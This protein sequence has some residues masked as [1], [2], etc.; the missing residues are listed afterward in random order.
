MAAMASVEVAVAA[1]EEKHPNGRAL[2]PLLGSLLAA[3][4]G[5]QLAA[6]PVCA[7]Q[8]EEAEAGFKF[9][10]FKE[11]RG[12]MSVHAPLAWVKG[13]LAEGWDFDASTMLDTLS[14]ASPQYVTNRGGQILHGLSSASIR[15]KR[16]EQTLKLTRWIGDHSVGLGWGRSEE[17]DYDSETLSIE[18]R[19]E[20]FEK[21][22]TLAFGASGTRD[23]ISA[24]GNP[25]LRESRHTSNWFVGLTQLLSPTALIQANIEFIDGSG[26][27]DDPYKFTLSFPGSR[28]LVQKDHRPDNRRGT[29]FML[30]HRKFLP[31][32][33]AAVSA[34][35]RHY[36]DDWGIR[37]LMFDLSWHQNFSAG[38]SLRPSL[39]FYDQNAADFFAQS[40]TTTVPIGSSDA[41]LGAFGAWSAGVKLRKDF[42]NGQSVDLTA[43][44]YRQRAQWRLFGSGSDGLPDYSAN[45]LMAGWQIQ[46]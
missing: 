5:M 24:T 8:I 28:P 31:A 30:R 1:T 11:N 46:F 15:E 25:D 12:R 27:Y 45:F 18:S 10:H 9:Y 16:R 20:L 22:V 34:D 33:D 17:H 21:N 3:C 43:G 32:L 44:T 19:L 41:R 29:A 39:R 2:N 37:S 14:G 38:W 4:A 6:A 23:R 40:F 35:F 7:G 26:F 36:R 42:G 13:P